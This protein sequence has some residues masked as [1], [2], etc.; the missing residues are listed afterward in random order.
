ETDEGILAIA[1]IRDTTDRKRVER[2]LH[3]AKEEAERAN[4]AKSEFLSRMSHEL[5]TPLTAILGFGQ[6]IEKQSPAGALR[7]RASHITVAGRHLLNLINEVLDISRIEAA[8]MQLSFEPVCLA[9]LLDEALDIMPSLASV[10]CIEF[11]AP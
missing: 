4:R 10:P 2:E 1:A 5:R 9:N 3:A 8:A 11:L 7:T 6:L